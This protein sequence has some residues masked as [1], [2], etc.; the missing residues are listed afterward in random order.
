MAITARNIDIVTV[1]EVLIDLTQTG[2]D[3]R[4]VR[5]LA[6]NPGGAPANVAVAASRLGTK[7]TFVG[8]IGTDAFGDSLRETLEKDGVD[9]TGLI[10]HETIPTT[11]AVVT[12]NPDG[13]RS[14]TFY[15]RPGADICLERSAIPE[16]LIA[17]A[18]IL[19]FGSVSLT[20]DPA[21]TA[22]L[23]AAKDAKAAGAIIT[24]DP[25]YRPALWPS[26]E[27]AIQ[28]MRAPLDMVD[29][30]KISDEETALLSGFE[31]PDAAAEA[32]TDQGIRLVLVTL[33]PD[34]VYYR[35]QPEDGE[36][37]TGTVPGFQVTV[38]DTNGAGD[39]F[40]G[41]F[42][43]KLSQ[44]E[45][46]LDDF[47]ADELEADL[48]FANRAASLTTSKPGA[49]PAMPTLEEVEAAL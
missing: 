20:D 48:T 40:F 23:E 27:E 33:G 28:W 10:A 43:S 1:G 47:E 13:E 31:A 7:T 21:R 17:D 36:A 35:Y 46:G 26:E 18:P 45:N 4:G 19:H 22:T 3:E 41:A 38:A 8:C 12:V 14:F 44:R 30:L 5:T 9:T 2:V 29:V 49:I 39:T 6:A 16:S 11:L 15:R 42:L 37:L 32:L 34:G 24:Y 25:N